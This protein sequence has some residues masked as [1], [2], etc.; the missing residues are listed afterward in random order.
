MAYLKN[1]RGK[2]IFVFLRM[3]RAQKSIWEIIERRKPCRI[4]IISAG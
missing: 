4:Q 1:K 3:K 2:I